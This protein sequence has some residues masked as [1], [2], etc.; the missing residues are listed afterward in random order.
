LYAEFRNASESEK[1]RINDDAVFEIELIKQVEVNVDYIL[2]LVERY[3]KAKDTGEDQEIRVAID[4]AVSSSPS[5]R[6]KKDLIEQFVDAVSTTARVDT[7]WLAFIARE[8]T[9]KPNQIIVHKDSM[10]VKAFVDNAFRDGAI[11]N[12]QTATRRLTH[13]YSQSGFIEENVKRR[14]YPKRNQYEVAQGKD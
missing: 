2:M 10:L 8:K 3:I 6:N 4:R 1:E 7:E 14:K 12:S 5:L 9:E 13:N 11:P